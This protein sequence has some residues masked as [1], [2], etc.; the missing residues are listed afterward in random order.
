MTVWLARQTNWKTWRTFKAA[1]TVRFCWFHGLVPR[2]NFIWGP[3]KRFDPMPQRT[4]R[5]HEC[6]LTMRIQTTPATQYPHHRD[7]GL[8]HPLLEPHKCSPSH[9]KGR[10]NETERNRMG[11]WVGLEP[12]YRSNLE[13]A[14]SLA[15]VYLFCFTCVCSFSLSVL[16]V[17]WFLRLCSIWCYG[18]SLLVATLFYIICSSVR[19]FPLFTL[20]LSL[21]LHCC[22]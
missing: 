1:A 10:G 5:S 6:C 12:Q 8:V 17:S 19:C 13:V 2:I 16:L 20:V 22:F 11:R 14:L 18:L 9:M 3:R 7:W 4:S 21:S 15:S